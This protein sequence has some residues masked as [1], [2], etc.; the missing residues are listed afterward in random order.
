MSYRSVFRPQLF[1]GKVAL[2]TGGGSGLGRCIAHELA[3]LGATVAIL[4]RK[5]EKLDAVRAE[6]EAAGGRCST[7]VGDIRDEDRMRQIVAESLAAHGR[8]DALVNNA[9]G[10][11]PS[12]LASI[13]AKGWDAVVRS[14]LS[15]GFVVARECFNQWMGEHGGAIV[16]I[17]ADMWHGMPGMGHS[18]AA[19]A[20]MLN[21]T[22]TAALEWAPVRVNAV[23]PGWIASSGMDQ[24]PP[25]MTEL[26][27][28]M[29]ALVPL[30][31]LG[32]ESEV[33]AA[34]CFLLSDAAAFISGACLRI[35]GAAPNAKR[36]WPEV[37]RGG[38]T[39]E[40]NGFHLASRPKVL[41][42]RLT[43]RRLHRGSI[44]AGQV[45]DSRLG[46]RALQH[47]PR[48]AGAGGDDRE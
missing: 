32:T 6:I 26:I 16:N 47:S 45:R 27:R 15:G 46:L 5:A 48:I 21:L 8:L 33:S 2:V 44:P 36:I 12:P 42:E 1:D 31:R 28:G 17:V 20:G 11:Y 30:Q 7:H 4:G 13:T 29:K 14:N 24:Y 39:P 34:V 22:E 25:E 9:G 38:S 3:S 23:A 37:G 43:C 10:Q 18:G 19:R 40:F 35:D 41:G